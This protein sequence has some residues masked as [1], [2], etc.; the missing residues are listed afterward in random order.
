MKKQFEVYSDYSLQQLQ[1]NIIAKALEIGAIKIRPTDPFTWASGYRM[2]IY[3]DNRMLLAHPETRAMVVAGLFKLLNNEGIQPQI[4]AGTA[5]AG[6]PWA[7]ILA[8]ELGLPFVYIRDK[9]KDHG[10][11]NRIEGLDSDK[12]FND[13]KV[14]VVEDLMSTGLSS[15]DAVESAQEAK[16]NVYSCL[17]IFNYG[18]PEAQ[19]LFA[20]LTP[21][22]MVQSII[23]YPMLLEQAVQV[24]YLQPEQIQLLENWSKNPKQ[25]GENNGFP[26]I[27][28]K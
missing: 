21:P 28:R 25:W 24:N 8:H 12:D 5:T 13:A 4:I 16:G 17:S 1:Q 14:V 20:S 10:L 23:T 3:N 7:A 22:C 2:P 11:R 19:N 6:I 18:F 15:V 27:E 9:A 26:K